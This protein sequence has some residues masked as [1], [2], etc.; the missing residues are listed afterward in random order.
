MSNP[1]AATADPAVTL[2]ALSPAQ[3]AVLGLL[4]EAPAHGYQLQRRF[5]G[6]GDLA[7]VLPLEQASLYGTLKELAAHGLIRGVEVREGARP[8][9]TVYEVTPDGARALDRWLKLP[10]ERLRRIRLD[11]L[12]KVY[13]T[14]RRG[15]R[16]L[17]ALV[18][19]QIAECESYLVQLEP[20]AAEVVA[21]EFASLVVGSRVSAARSTLDWLRAYQER[22]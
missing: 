17:R 11:F 7:T 12:L 9:K 14:R 21:D 19:A 22:L 20:R 10:V 4:H 13:F 6:D 1:R 15:R 5:T 18:D 8:P 2:T 3:Y 16:A